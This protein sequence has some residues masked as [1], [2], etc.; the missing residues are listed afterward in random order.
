MVARKFSVI[1][2]ALGALLC[3]AV[4][5]AR[6]QQSRGGLRGTVQDASGAPLAGATVTAVGREG[7]SAGSATADS[8]GRFEIRELAPGTYSLRATHSGFRDGAVEGLKVSAGQSKRV[9]LRLEAEAKAAGE[10][11]A[12]ASTS[13][14]INETQLAGL[15]LNGR[16]YTQLATLQSEVT[17]PFGGSA[18]RGGG[19]GG[20]NVAGSRSTSNNFLLDGTNIMNT[21]NQVPQSA[22]GVQLGSDA[23]FQVQVFSGSYG[24]E[25]GRDSGGVLNSI[26]R[27]GTPQLHGSLFEYFRNS[28]MDARNFFDPASPPPFKRNQFG[29][30]VTGPARKDRTFFTGSFEAMRDRF[31][32]TNIDFYPDILARQ[33]IITD[34]AGN[35]I[36]RVA[37]NPKVAPYLALYPLP[38]QPVLGNG[39]GQ[40]AAP[41][42]LPTNESFFAIRLDHTISKNDSIFG[43]YTFDDANSQAGDSSTLYN[44]LV[45]SRQQY[46]T[47]TGSHIFHGSLL[48]SYRAAFTRTAEVQSSI[49][50]LVVPRALFFVPDAINFGQISVPGLST[51]GPSGNLTETNIMNTFQFGGD[52]LARTGA[53]NWKLGGEIHRYRWAPQS[54]SN[55]GGLWSFNSL[56]SFLTGGPG[57]TN[58]SVALPPS[59]NR[60]NHRQTLVGL[61]LQD[62]YK[63]ASNLQLN[64]GIRYEFTTLIHDK[65][66]RT[67]YMLDPVRDQEARVG[68]VVKDNPSLLNFSPRV[69]ISWSPGG[70]KSTSVIGGFGIYHDQ[71]LAYVLDGPKSSAP[72]YRTAVRQNFDSSAVFP[73]AVAA[74][75]GTP[76]QA[77]PLDYFHWKNPSVFRYNLAI[78]RQW[79]GWRLQ[80]SYVGA[81]GNHLYRSY[82]INL[83]PVPVAGA[84]NSIFFPPNSGPINPA[85]G[86]IGLVSSDAQS[87][88]NSLQV[89]AGKGIG[90]NFTSQVSYTLSKSVDD[91][92]GL[93]TNS[94]YG[95]LRTEERGL[96]DF[97][98]RQRL[99]LNFFYTAP[100]GRGQRWLRS[101]AGAAVLGGWRVGSIVSVRSGT[102]STLSVNVRTPGFLYA[103]ARPNLIPGGNNNP[104]GG[105]TAGCAGV[106]AGLPLPTPS[107]FFD[108]CQFSV[109][110][111][112]TLGNL[113]RNTVEGP[114]VFSLDVSLQR[115]F[116]VDS[117]R[118]LQ[119][120]AE[121]FNLP[122]HPN[123][124]GVTGAATTVFTGAT[125]R[126]NPN[127]GRLTQPITTARQLQFALRFSF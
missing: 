63:L 112:G 113:G 52:L 111:P 28:K 54:H 32:Q 99:V 26:S 36:E 20:L 108:P 1:A 9:P 40:A 68:A 72:F 14:Q 6:A 117:K 49:A 29:F 62:G 86:A 22:A 77:R 2:L 21:G 89:S 91:A 83:F 100:A 88:Y 80:A 55:S 64:L 35:V 103:P 16:S 60:K 126:R 58:L 47:L 106:D 93:S 97:D 43:R 57:G 10:G 59:N 96:S 127:A 121:F 92:S 90:K 18:S 19:G 48:G 67:S 94:Q 118:R 42:F 41:Q 33:G 84:N 78:Q 87:F 104:I 17:D 125:G 105:A 70:S 51:L 39:I 56:D 119:F 98:I 4:P 12:A 120:R 50:K 37:V 44:K 5:Q 79:K 81:R 95:A 23:I 74:A 71:L 115:E 66:G 82:E 45:Q 15:P 75:S 109:P 61:Y 122:N 101:G 102:P 76:F 31:T 46:L 24:P 53:H 116:M 30:T 8:Q 124:R 69:G 25:Y 123:F 13:G 114:R 27:S 85:F 38:N 11:A 7:D 34:R 110:A 3:W 65:D 73:D 107:L